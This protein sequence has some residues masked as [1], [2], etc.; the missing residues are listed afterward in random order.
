MGI[1]DEKTSE[2]DPVS[3]PQDT[4]VSRDLTGQVGQ[5][6]DVQLAEPSLIAWGVDPGQMSKVRVSGASNNLVRT[7]MRKHYYF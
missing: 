6:G 7:R 1:N 3:V 4:V 2:S 5:E